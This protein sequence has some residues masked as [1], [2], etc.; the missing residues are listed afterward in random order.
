M[1]NLVYLAV[2]I[3]FHSIL[4][5]FFRDVDIIGRKIFPQFGPVIFTGTF[6]V[7]AYCMIRR[8]NLET[9]VGFI[10]LTLYFYSC[11]VYVHY[12]VNHAN[13]FIDAVMVPCT[14]QHK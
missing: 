3:F 10:D 13:Q 2:K 4:S 1:K 5:I 11:I 9:A 6:V 8:S 7:L 14:C 12:T